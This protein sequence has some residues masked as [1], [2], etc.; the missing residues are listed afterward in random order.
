MSEFDSSNHPVS[1]VIVNFFTCV[2]QTAT[3]ICYKFGVDVS[4]FDHYKLGLNHGVTL[5]CQGIWVILCNCKKSSLIKSMTRNHSCLLW[6]IHR[7]PSF[8]F[9]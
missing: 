2:L 5:I 3:Q 6:R 8:Y 4:W 7:G 9:L 1:V